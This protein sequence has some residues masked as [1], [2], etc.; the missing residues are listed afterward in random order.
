MPWKETLQNR[1][2]KSNARNHRKPG[3]Q[4]LKTKFASSN[5]PA[6]VNPDQRIVVVKQF[7]KDDLN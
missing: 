1:I 7:I 5:L 4:C 6:L 3:A 2:P